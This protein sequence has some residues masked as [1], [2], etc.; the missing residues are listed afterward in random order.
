MARRRP[1]LWPKRGIPS[2]P[3]GTLFDDLLPLARRRKMGMRKRKIAK[4]IFI[5]F[6]W[7]WCI[8]VKGGVGGVLIDWFKRDRELMVQGICCSENLEGTGQPF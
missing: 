7:L 8:E 3:G 2:D 4:K 1:R 6:V 5:I